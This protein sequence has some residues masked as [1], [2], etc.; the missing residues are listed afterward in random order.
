MLKGPFANVGLGLPPKNPMK[1]VQ[2]KQ[3][4]SETLISVIFV[5]DKINDF[6]IVRPKV[7]SKIAIHKSKFKGVRKVSK[8][9][10]S[11]ESWLAIQRAIICG[12]IGGMKSMCSDLE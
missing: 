5:L 3:T 7:A 10:S 6:R 4:T 9:K 1:E 12:E 11:C 8:S 2:E